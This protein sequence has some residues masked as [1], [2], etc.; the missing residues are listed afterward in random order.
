VP[1]ADQLR[2]LLRR[3]HSRLNDIS[4]YLDHT[5]A[6]WESFR[7]RTAEGF[8]ATGTSRATGHPFNHSDLVDFRETYEGEM[9]APMIL[10]RYLSAFESFMVGFLRLLL[11]ESPGVLASKTIKLGDLLAKGS[12]D[13]VLDDAIEER[14]LQATYGKPK[15]WFDFVNTIQRL[16]CPSDDE[17][18]RF[19]ELK[20]TRDVFEHNDGTANDV[21]LAKSGAKARFTLGRAVEVPD[22]YLFDARTL[23][24]KM[25]EDMAAALLRVR[26]ED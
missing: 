22:I 2:D 7:L 24:T 16:G 20:A 26:A 13:A 1:V 17:I 10:Q 5:R 19:A 11:R 12:I 8:V 23:L 4:D 6:V 25:C 3:T 18:A 14:I 15:D 21:Y 9:I